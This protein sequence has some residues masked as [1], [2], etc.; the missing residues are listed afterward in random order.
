[1]SDEVSD[2]RARSQAAKIVQAYGE[3]VPGGTTGL[4]NYIATTP[5]PN[6]FTSVTNEAQIDRVN[7]AIEEWERWSLRPPG[8]RVV[9]FDEMTNEIEMR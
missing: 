8:P 3:A 5:R 6:L 7:R 1:M 2:A 4:H 9:S